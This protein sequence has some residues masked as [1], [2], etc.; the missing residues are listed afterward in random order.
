MEKRIRQI[1][2]PPREIK[3][4]EDLRQ[5]YLAE[6]KRLFESLDESISVVFLK[7]KEYYDDREFREKLEEIL[8]DTDVYGKFPG[9]YF[10]RARIIVSINNRDFIYEYFFGLSYNHMFSN[11][12]VHQD[13]LKVIEHDLPELQPKMKKW[14]EFYVELSIL[15]HKYKKQIPAPAKEIKV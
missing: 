2:K 11:V 3:Q 13:M 12:E 8:E 15:F 7:E 4:K 14:E 5:R 6:W 9:S 10:S 1:P